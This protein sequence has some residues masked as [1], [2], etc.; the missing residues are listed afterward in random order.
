ML[1]RYLIL[2]ASALVGCDESKVIVPGERIGKYV[3]GAKSVDYSDDEILVFT[4]PYGVIN[5][6]AVRS[7]EYT[8][9]GRQVIGSNIE[10]LMRQFS[11][12]KSSQ[13][14]YDKFGYHFYC[15]ASQGVGFSMAEGQVSSV[16]VFA[17]TQ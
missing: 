4:D 17:A 8:L 10:P 9:A 15:S 16:H 12:L 6:V 5:H 1:K 14:H 13:P 2:I 7:P 3:L 11:D